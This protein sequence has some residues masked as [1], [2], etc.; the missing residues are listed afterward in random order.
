MPKARSPNREKA[1]ELYKAHGG[2]IDLV[3]IATELN[4][5]AGTIRGWKNKD[6][7]KERL[8][9]TLPKNMERSQPKKHGGQPGNKNAVGHKPSTPKGN[10][11]AVKH[12]AYQT[13]YTQFL[14]EEER[15]IY[16]QISSDSDMD[17][18]IKLLRLKITRLLSR[19]TTHCYDMFGNCHHIEVSEED[20]ER[21]IIAC[22]KQLEKLIKTKEQIKL[23]REK[24]ELEKAKQ[25][26]DNNRENELADKL[27]GLIDE[28][29]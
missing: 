28:L 17:E 9:G 7:W 26:D 8:N 15:Q 16:E 12:G 29:E 18:E 2:K 14:P 4:L 27:R 11:N 20:R 25:A 24:L 13:I 10:L 22:M 1:F 23:Q 3:E 5:P 21:G 6:R 19:E